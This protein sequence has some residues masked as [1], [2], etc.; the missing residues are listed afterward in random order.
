MK[1]Y[2][3]ERI[4]EAIGLPQWR[5]GEIQSRDQWIRMATNLAGGHRLR[6]SYRPDQSGQG[7]NNRRT[8]DLD[9]LAATPELVTYINQ[10]IT[11][12]PQY[13]TSTQK[14]ELWQ[15]LKKWEAA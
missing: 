9:F 2:R 4:Y 6:A 5:R 3:T 10:H 7:M 11:L 14:D 1:Y 12:K 13:L 15:E 8:V